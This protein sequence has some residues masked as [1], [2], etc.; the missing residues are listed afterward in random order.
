VLLGQEHAQLLRCLMCLWCLT[1]LQVPSASSAHYLCCPKHPRHM[2]HF[3][4]LAAPSI[5]LRRRLS[6]R[7]VRS[8][9]PGSS[10]RPESAT[11]A[12]SRSPWLPGR[13]F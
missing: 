7:P 12:D 4:H 1:C 3:S 8:E 13:F 11:T 6:A 10:P 2:R 9:M 5:L